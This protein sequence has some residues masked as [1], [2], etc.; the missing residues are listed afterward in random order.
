MPAKVD[1]GAR[2]D[3]AWG[4]GEVNVHLGDLEIFPRE[5]EANILQNIQPILSHMHRAICR[6]EI[7]SKKDLNEYILR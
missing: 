6:L 3:G 4:R 2:V 1:G 7:I 5:Y